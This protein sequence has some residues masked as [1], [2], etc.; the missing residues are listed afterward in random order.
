MAFIR[1]ERTASGATAV[2]IAQKQNGKIIKLQHLEAPIPK[3]N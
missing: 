1:K 3:K 2:Q